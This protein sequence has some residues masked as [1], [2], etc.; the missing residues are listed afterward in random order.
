MLV[1][2]LCS[3]SPEKLR[4]RSTV[5]SVTEILLTDCVEVLGDLL[6]L[7]LYFQHHVHYLCF[8]ATKLL[9]LT[10]NITLFFSSSDSLCYSNFISA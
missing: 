9:D 8:H 7:K 10:R 2:P 5:S 1:K 4:W 6:R 3:L